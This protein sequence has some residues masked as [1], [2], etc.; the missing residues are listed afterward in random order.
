MKKLSMLPT[1]QEQLKVSI[2]QGLRMPVTT[3]E[4]NFKN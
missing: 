3:G 4:I 1:R 2:L